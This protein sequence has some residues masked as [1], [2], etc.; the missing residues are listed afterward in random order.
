MKA[1]LSCAALILLTTT[2]TGGALIGCNASQLERG[3]HEVQFMA[4]GAAPAEGEQPGA[5][6]SAVRAAVQLASAA[7]PAVGQIA[8][9]VGLLAGAV[10]GIAGHFNGKR[11]ATNESKTVIDEIAHSI[12][13]FKDPS[14]PFTTKTQQTLEALGHVALARV[15]PTRVELSDGMVGYIDRNHA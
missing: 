13:T 14:E 10:G 9:L 4:G 2:L 5:G 1:R 7:N 11:S 15:E 8:G 3:A 6:Q 12:A